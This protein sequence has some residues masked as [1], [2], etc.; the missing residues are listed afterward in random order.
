MENKT[1]LSFGAIVLVAVLAGTGW[2]YFLSHSNQ[3]TA[4]PPLERTIPENSP[5][6]DTAARERTIADLNNT[7]E[8][9]KENPTSYQ[10][11]VYLG[12][13]R[14]MLADY[15]G[16]AEAWEYA[17]LLNSSTEVAHTNL[18]YVYMTYLKSYEKAEAN[19]LLA[20]QLNSTNINTYRS[21]YELYTYHYKKD[22]SAAED[23]LKQGIKNNAEAVDLHTLLARF[24]HDAGR[25]AEAKEQYNVAIN[26]ARQVGNT[27]AEDALKKERDSF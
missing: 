21:L 18:G 16:A 19:Y 2:Q 24:Y 27:S 23:I 14:Q 20:L 12:A 7:I 9:L 25:V 6:L 11:W 3:S 17:V 26:V 13:Y 8:A 5:D 15:V 1:L 4:Y 22:T 10:N